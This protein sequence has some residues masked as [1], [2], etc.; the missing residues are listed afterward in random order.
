MLL[1]PHHQALHEAVFCNRDEG[2]RA[3]QVGFVG[4]RVWGTTDGAAAGDRD[5]DGAVGN[6][7]VPSVLVEWLSFSVES[8]SFL[9]E[10]VDQL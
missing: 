1:V 9:G 7:L 8:P 5:E 2:L 4:L 6:G 10:K 3:V